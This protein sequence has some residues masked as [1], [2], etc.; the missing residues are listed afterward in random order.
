MLNNIFEIESE[1]A[2]KITM[3]F[4][5][6]KDVKAR[7]NYVR[8]WRNIIIADI[9]IVEIINELSHHR[10]PKIKDFC[11]LFIGQ[12]KKIQKKLESNFLNISLIWFPAEKEK[13]KAPKK[14]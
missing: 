9:S 10:K 4:E 2:Q 13:K 6:R 8:E 14:V 1:L 3:L 11:L 12:A 7:G 5:N